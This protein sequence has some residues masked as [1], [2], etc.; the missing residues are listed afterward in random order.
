MGAATDF[1]RTQVSRCRSMWHG[2]GCGR[3][4]C[5]ASKTGWTN[6]DG[7]NSGAIGAPESVRLYPSPQASICGAPK[8][9]TSAVRLSERLADLRGGQRWRF[10]TA[11]INPMLSPVFRSSYQTQWRSA[12]CGT[13]GPFAGALVGLIGAHCCGIKHTAD[14]ARSLQ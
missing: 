7:A 6:H 1:T 12:V 11:V 4:R 14:A 9:L 10:S 5:S 3:C 13:P 8:P 2:G